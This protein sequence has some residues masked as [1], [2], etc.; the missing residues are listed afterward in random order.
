[1]R[2]G[3]RSVRRALN[4]GQPG[5]GA[6]ADPFR[7]ADFGGWRRARRE[8]VDADL[9]GPRPEGRERRD[10]RRPAA[11]TGRRRRG[12]GPGGLRP[13]GPAAAHPHAAR[14]GLRV[15]V[16]RRRGRLRRGADLAA[17]RSSRCASACSSR[18]RRRRSTRC[19]ARTRPTCC[20]ATASA[21][22][23]ALGILVNLPVAIPTVV[24]G[25]SLLLLWGPDR[26]ARPAPR[27]ARHPADVRARGRAPRAP[28]RD[29]PVHARRGQAGARRARGDLRGGGLHDR[30]EPLADVPLG[31]P[32]G[33]A[34]RAL[35]R[36][37]C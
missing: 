32:A 9:E 12:H 11:R 19:S 22:E 6:I 24:V 26:P 30:R 10:E 5:F 21:G 34:R 36:A 16:P 25:T 20:R 8:I 18:S 28:L 29:V 17:R 13:A 15:R 23:R 35:H 33:A 31:H 7:I 2:Y 14:G 37:R 1:M 27:A 3:F 4:A